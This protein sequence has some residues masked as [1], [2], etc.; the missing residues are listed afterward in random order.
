MRGHKEDERMLQS[1][2]NNT[3]KC[4]VNVNEEGRKERGRNEREKE[5]EEENEEAGDDVQR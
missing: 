5:M 4:D 2:T 1:V 3:D